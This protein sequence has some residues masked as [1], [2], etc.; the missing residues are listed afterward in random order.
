MED[1]QEINKIEIDQNILKSLNVTRKWTMFLAIVGFI[2]FGIMLVFGILAGTFMSAF[3]AG[4]SGTVLKE[5]AM[6]I[7]LFVAILAYLFPVLFL[8]R[9]SK[10][11]ALAVHHLDKKELNKAFKNLKYLFVCLGILVI[12][13][14]CAYIGV[15]IF[16][17]SSLTL[18]KGF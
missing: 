3:S 15:L 1:S 11:A 17:G 5:S 14:L 12:I 6:I 10:N 13:V 8:F 9:F 18:L 4:S 7:C 16:T 2:F